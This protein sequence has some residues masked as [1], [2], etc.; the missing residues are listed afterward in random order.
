MG[1]VI[2]GLFVVVIAIAIFF[3]VAA[4]LMI[5]GV[6]L[7]APLA[8]ALVSFALAIEVWSAFELRSN[9]HGHAPVLLTRET[10]E[11]SWQVGGAAVQWPVLPL[12]VATVAAVAAV[13]IEAP[14][15]EATVVPNDL[16]IWHAATNLD[17]VVALLAPFCLAA[18]LRGSVY[19]MA[20]GALTRRVQAMFAPYHS[21]IE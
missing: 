14:I 12:V 1:R 11:T 3:A 10:G 2:G 15:F 6:L 13:W 9:P 21:L 20:R 16:P 8:A 7:I 5:A 17:T 4:F 19:G 18:S